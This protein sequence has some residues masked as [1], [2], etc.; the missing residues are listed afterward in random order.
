LGRK[1]RPSAKM[2]SGL[3]ESVARLWE[4]A[5]GVVF[6]A[7]S[8]SFTCHGADVRLLEVREGCDVLD[9]VGAR[10]FTITTAKG[11]HRCRLTC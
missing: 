9:S 10:T 4:S 7:W 2:G 1:V 3:S 8:V 5:S 11:R 6:V